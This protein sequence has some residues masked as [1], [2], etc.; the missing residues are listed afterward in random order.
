VAFSDVTGGRP[1][2]MCDDVMYVY[3]TYLYI[4]LMHIVT[5]MCV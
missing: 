3:D 4:M 1:G 2:L 5:E